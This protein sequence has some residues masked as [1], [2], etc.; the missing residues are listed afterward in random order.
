M[1]E[2]TS[3]VPPFN[4]SAHNIELSLSICKG[5]RPEVIE[6]TPQCYVDLMKKC[7]NEDPLER[8]S[9]LEI[10]NIIGNWIFYSSDK[11]NDELLGNIMEFINAPIEHNN[12]AIETHLKAVYTS[13]L[14]AFTSRRLF[15]S[16][17]SQVYEIS[18]SEDLNDCIIDTGLLLGLF[19]FNEKLNEILK[20]KEL[21][22]YEISTSEDLNDC[23]IRCYF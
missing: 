12:L 21:Q 20:N 14:L 4:S 19:D 10:K 11:I 17:D 2:F 18:L 5:E 23:C 22:V 6:N 3:G 15:D 7:W 1:W 9:A 16:E 13:Q 8:P